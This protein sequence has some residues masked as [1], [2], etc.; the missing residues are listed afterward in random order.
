MNNKVKGQLVYEI[1]C[2]PE[3]GIFINE[4]IDGDVNSKNILSISMSLVSLLKKYMK[5]GNLE[6]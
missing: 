2:S 6:L 5:I 4:F 3:K 1:M